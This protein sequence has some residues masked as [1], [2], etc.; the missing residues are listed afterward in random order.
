MRKLGILVTTLLACGDR[1][2]PPPRSP[3]APGVPPATAAAHH[4]APGCPLM[5][6]TPIDRSN[7]PTEG[8]EGESRIARPA[9]GDRC[10]TADSN[11]A[12]VEK[13]ILASQDHGKPARSRPWDHRTP[14]RFAGLVERRFA[15]RPAE[16]ERIAD[17]GF[18]VLARHSFSNYGMAFHEIYQSQ[19]PVF[20]SIDAVLHAIYAG[21]DSLI[22]EL[23]DTR[24]RG[25]LA[26]LL[27]RLSCTLPSVAVEYP[28][29]TARDLDLY[30]AVAQALLRG[31][32]PSSMSGDPAVEAEARAIVAR[33]VAAG[34]MDTEH[35]VMM[36]G[37]RRVIDFTAY[38]PRGHYAANEDRQRYFRAGMW[39]SRIE[40]NLVS[41]SSRSSQPGL[42][43]DPRE[44]PREDLAALALADLIDRTR[45]GDAV[46]RLD[47]AWALLA[48][49]RED[50]SVA[51]LSELRRAARIERLTEPDA[52]DRLRAAIGDRFPRTARL[53][54]MPQGSKDLPVI[55]TLL[56]PRVVPDAAATRPI[57]TGEVP[58]RT[59]VSA[60][61]MAYVLGHD[62]ARHHLTDELARFPTLGAQL[63]VARE[64]V[65]HGR[66]G[67]GDLYSAWLGA[68]I[69]LR[70]QHHGAWP[71]FA[72]T[73]AYADFR[74]D[75]ALAAFGHIK[76][77]Y[78][79]LAGESYFEGGCVIPDGYVEP[80]PGTYQML[81][82]YAR[83]GKAAMAVLDHD[84]ALGGAAYF[85]RL[86]QVLGVLADIQDTELADRPLSADQRAFLSMVAEM[87]PGMTGAPPSY[88]GWWFDMFRRREVDGLT[89]ADYLASFFTGESIAYVGATAPRLGV[90]IVD[91]GGPPR[92]MVGP[93]ARAYQY[94]GPV[95][96]RL[97]DAAGRELPEAE[98]DDPWAA[99]YTVPQPAEPS[100]RLRWD[101]AD[102]DPAI[103]VET[104][105]ALG[106]VTIEMYDHHRTPM[107]SLTRDVQ[108]GKTRF[109][110][111]RTHRR[112]VE[113]LHLQV[114]DYDGWFDLGAVEPI[115]WANLGAYKA[116]TDDE[117]P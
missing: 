59:A 100:L 72:A 95:A 91:T 56:G 114:G 7:E 40:L 30:L 111:G 52:A 105:A 90:F 80:A 15:F 78:V 39:L 23:E 22:A 115:V 14:P 3:A 102:D 57:V 83:R 112:G 97:D 88:T 29:E 6:L 74:I 5:P 51:Q 75:S 36:F 48:G 37:R 45:Q 117:S 8:V 64:T 96:H 24:L 103:T 65:V 77:N 43:P 108:P 18:A 89:P 107:A 110:V 85:A 17:Q 71:S 66:L 73:P 58:G 25:E 98:R 70:E 20:V 13:A 68:V 67:D 101:P 104:E 94:Q 28:A 27:D 19:L 50:V 38:T 4:T 82:D 46:A 54:Y 109:E 32:A 49:R 116:M 10:A 2:P 53:H 44:T 87:E 11:L 26:D 69:A 55:A 61:D 47:T 92:M 62:R 86:E 79:L 9:H 60:V 99:S 34:E 76:H 93:V 113:G 84:G 42:S 12:R 41:R 16:H 33:A 81:L 35:G 21:N 1:S 63:D 31:T 106:R